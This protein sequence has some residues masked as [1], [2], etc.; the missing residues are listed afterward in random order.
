MEVSATESGPRQAELIEAV[1]QRQAEIVAAMHA[2]ATNWLEV[3]LTMAQ[4]KT[5]VV[6]ADEGP[7][8]IGV[9][10]DALGVGLPTASHLVERLVRAGL[11]RRVEDPEDRR[12]ALASITPNGEELL[13]GLREGGRERLRLYLRGLARD[14]LQALVQGL[15]ALA[16]AIGRVERREREPAAPSALARRG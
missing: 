3:D 16:R 4:M 7:A 9:V 12:R 13:R 1:L 11:A 14:D 5:L 10:G 2:G 6:L 15:S 8:A